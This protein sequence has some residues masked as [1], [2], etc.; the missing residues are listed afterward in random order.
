MYSLEK[1]VILLTSC[2]NFVHFVHF[3]M[4]RSFLYFSPKNIYKNIVY[5]DSYGRY[6]RDLALPSSSLV[7]HHLLPL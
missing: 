1:N 3:V 5:F 4:Y 2:W 7:V 6:A